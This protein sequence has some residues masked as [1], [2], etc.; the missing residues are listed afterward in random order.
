[1]LIFRIACLHDRSHATTQYA[2]R[3]TPI[4]SDLNWQYG[5]S[6]TPSISVH[7]SI[8]IVRDSGIHDTTWCLWDQFKRITSSSS[9]FLHLVKETR[10]YISQRGRE[11][12]REEE[13]NQFD[14]IPSMILTSVRVIV[15][16]IEIINE[17]RIR[18]IRI[19]FTSANYPP[20]PAWSLQIHP[21]N[22]VDCSHLN[23]NLH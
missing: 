23:S 16:T 13:G 12:R 21:D 11:T 3:L 8:T 6:S 9:S 7:D 4:Q 1:M 5:S 15:R 19:D 10:I 22:G 20:A 14:P 18:D 2:I 17:M